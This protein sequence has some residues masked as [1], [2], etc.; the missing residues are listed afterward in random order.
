MTNQL[1]NTGQDCS[2]ELNGILS[3]KHFALLLTHSNYYEHS[4]EG[5]FINT[6]TCNFKISPSY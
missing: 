1:S 2:K 3:A 4:Q 6:L 5:K